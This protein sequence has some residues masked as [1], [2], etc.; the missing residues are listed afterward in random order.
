[1]KWFV[2]V[3]LLLASI[4]GSIGLLA[5]LA[6]EASPDPAITVDSNAD[7]DQRDGVITLREAILLATGDLALG[8]LDSSEKDNVT[9]TP[10]PGSADTITFDPAVFPPPPMGPA[11]I[12]LDSTLP[13]L[14]TGNDVV[15]GSSAGVVLDGLYRWFDCLQITSN[16][17]SVRGLQI[18]DCDCGVRIYGG[19]Q[20]NTVGGTTAAARNVLTGSNNGVYIHDPSTSDNFVIGNYIGTDASGSYAIGNG[21]GVSIEGGAHDNTIGGSTA[22]ERNLISGNNGVGVGIGGGGTNNNV[23]E[24]NYI[25]TDASAVQPDGHPIPNGQGVAIYGGA[26]G[27]VV[28]GTSEGERNVISGNNWSGVTIWDA[29]TNKNVVS[30]NYIGTD[31]SGYN[32]M[33]NA[34]GVEISNGARN[35]VIGGSTTAERN[36]ISGNTW[37]GVRIGDSG[38]N[39]NAVKGNY[40]GTDPSGSVGLG[41]NGGGVTICCSAQSNTIG[42]PT[43]GERNVISANHAEGV[44]IGSAGTNSNVVIGNYIGT[45]ASGTASMG[46]DRGVW[47]GDAAQN[48]IIG[49][50]TPGGRNVISANN[51]EGVGIWGWG[52][53][54]N[55]VKGNYIGTDVSG[56]LALGNNQGGVNI[57]GGAQN[58]TIGG[59]TAGDRNTISGSQNGPGVSIGDDGTNNNVVK[60][61]YIGTD[62]SGTAALPNR[63]GV[64]IYWGARYNTVGGSTATERNVIS[65]SQDAAGVSIGG[66]GANGNTVKGNYIGTDASGT[67]ALPNGGGGVWIDNGAQN[68]TVGGSTAGDRN[69]ISGNNGSGVWIG[70]G[71]TNNNVVKGNYIGTN[72]GGTGGLANNGGGVGICCGAQNNTVGGSTAGDRN[73]ISGNNWSGVWINDGG[74]NGNVVKGNYIG[75]DAGGSAA[76]PNNDGVNV[77]CG[78]QNNTIGGSTAG[79]RNVISGNGPG[80]AV[81]IGGWDANNNVV[82]GNYIG[83]DA[84]GTAALPNQDG[85]NIHSGAQNNTVGGTTTGERNVISGNWGSGVWIG[86]WDTNGNVVKGNYIGTDVSGSYAIANNNGVSI[87]DGARDNIVGGPEPG[88]AN[89]IAGNDGDG[90]FIGGGGTGGNIVQ[91]NRVGTDPSGTATLPNETGVN[92]CCGAEE[93]TIG[94]ST[95][96]ERNIISG[97]IGDGVSIPG[98]GRNHVQGNYIGTDISGTIALSNNNGM[99]ICCGAYENTIGGSGPGEGNVIS[100]NGARGVNIDG[101]GTNNNVVSGNYI[102]TDASGIAALPNQVNGVVLING[103]NNNQI[104]GPTPEERN[105]ISGN[106]GFG[107]E[108]WFEGTNNNLVE[109]NYI[110]L[111]AAGA[112]LGDQYSGVYI[113]NGADNNTLRGNVISDNGGSGVSLGGMPYRLSSSPTEY[114]PVAIDDQLEVLLNGQTIFFEGTTTGSV[115]VPHFSAMRGDT[116]EVRASST[117]DDCG[118]IGPVWLTHLGTEEAS[119]QL[120]AGKSDCGP[121]GLFWSTTYAID[122][123]EGDWIASW[124][125]IEGNRIGTN[126]AGD[127]AMPNNG[128]G[129][130]LGRGSSDTLVGVNQEEGRGSPNLISGNNGDGIRIQGSW[131]NHIG[132]N[133]IGTDLSGSVA[134]PNHGPGIHMHQGAQNNTVSD[135]VIAGNEGDGVYLEGEGTS[136][137]RVRGSHIGVDASGTAQLANQGNGVTIAWGASGNSIGG[138]EEWERNVITGNQGWGVLIHNGAESNWVYNNYIGLDAAGMPDLPSNGVVISNGASHNG[139]YQNVISDNPGS[140]ITVGGLEYSL[141]GGM[142][143][144]PMAIDLDDRLEILVN[145]ETV[146]VGDADGGQIWPPGFGAVPGDTVEVRASDTDNGCGSIGPVWLY[147]VGSW[148]AIKL[149]DGAAGCGGTFWSTTL[150]LDFPGEGWITEGTWIGNNQI[151]TSPAGDAPMPNDGHGV[152]I[153]PASQGSFVYDNTI[154]FNADGVHVDRSNGNY[155]GSNSI[156]SNADDGV[157]IDAATGNSIRGNSIHSNGGKGIANINGGNNELPPPVL[158]GGGSV[159]GLSCPYCWIDVFSDQADE[160]AVYEGS[161]MVAADGTFVYPGT[162]SGPY[163]TATVTDGEGNTSEFSDP[164]VPVIVRME[165]GYAAPGGSVTLTLETLNI[166]DPGL[167]AFTIDVSYDPS[168]IEPTAFAP[169]PGFDSLVCSL[170]HA[171]DT[172]RCTGVRAGAGAV[173]DL[174]LA[175]LTFEVDAGAVLGSQSPLAVAVVTLANVDGQAIGADT[176][177]G[178]KIT[179]GLHGD[180]NCGGD[181]D[182]VDALFILQYVVGLKQAGD[183]CPP[184]PGALY[185]PAADVNCDND[186]DAV[187]ALFVLQYVVGLRPELGVCR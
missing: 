129:V 89:L 16:G 83:T 24:G 58:N 113:Y 19:A 135:N 154:A 28:G 122:I 118:S 22:G 15:D 68:N 86:H 169:G 155:I 102:G 165:S 23:V 9:G 78:A 128:P 98:G 117:D 171:S 108:I 114:E 70:N 137:N 104:G 184:P 2:V 178:A 173:G 136:G 69:V 103:P 130:E 39:G 115:Q 75:T 30:G 163:I 133:R 3:L 126:A 60:G 42:G 93:N 140:A 6:A 29:G 111:N 179:V 31:A 88:E 181:V 148:E 123:P 84:G 127:A 92:L 107:V 17:N 90:I 5:R 35:N 94:G 91:G 125:A 162:P 4:L 52:A 46:N 180:V 186:V 109:G 110:G 96:E 72:A 145:G 146:F 47:I 66:E 26:Q 18:H 38:T 152:D 32:G 13:P 175:D 99:N 1:M 143:K 27:N 172:I 36:V 25:G 149:T 164:M 131:G 48:N 121:D 57:N 50:S 120:T 167:G 141:G 74:T 174:A 158:T 139:V 153:R 183:Q 101:G 97:N 54:G 100:G 112:P 7:T 79:E 144:G 80:P 150:V 161:T 187:D 185:V 8:S 73:V 147:H 170:A 11:G 71:G 43:P 166:P 95:P 40:I 51:W 20:N 119:V 168:I 177:D 49:G 55:V 45:D 156:H 134:L 106:N 63:G 62:A 142:G 138:S 33:R 64:N 160:G 124:N 56:G 53:N 41:N 76:L 132:A 87:N 61:N 14:Y 34:T 105:I 82:K 67:A 12:H 37:S 21:T 10:G 85:V 116:L 44:W 157:Y 159:T 151:G 65:G 59:S 77:C 176:K 81:T 182:A